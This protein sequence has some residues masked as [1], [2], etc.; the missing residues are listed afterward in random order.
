MYLAFLCFQA[1]SLNQGI[2]VPVR[3]AAF[4]EHMAVLP[5][6]TKIVLFHPVYMVENKSWDY[7]NK[8]SIVLKVAQHSS[9]LL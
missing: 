5:H 3:E 1:L 2:F 8:I 7:F 9:S 6:G 4:A